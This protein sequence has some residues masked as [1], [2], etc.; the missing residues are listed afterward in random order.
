VDISAGTAVLLYQ[1]AMD[2]GANC[3]V[4]STGYG[5]NCGYDRSYCCTFS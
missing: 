4:I 3:S 1:F 2:K 5:V